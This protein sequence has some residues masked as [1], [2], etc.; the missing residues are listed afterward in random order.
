MALLN[1]SSIN[2]QFGNF[3]NITK[4]T[5]A[6]RRSLVKTRIFHLTYVGYQFVNFSMLT[7]NYF[8]V[9]HEKI[10]KN[11]NILISPIYHVSFYKELFSVDNTL[12]TGNFSCGDF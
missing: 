8:K 4:P 10:Y 9:A 2:L 1:L 12:I 6:T 3:S 7:I 5:D 11:N